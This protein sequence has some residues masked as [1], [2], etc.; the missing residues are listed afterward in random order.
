MYH[1]TSI[2]KLSENQLRKL[3][4]GE[5]VMLS[6][7]LPTGQEPLVIALESHTLHKEQFTPLP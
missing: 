1:P 4:K 7:Q 5:A 3:L 6:A 2:A